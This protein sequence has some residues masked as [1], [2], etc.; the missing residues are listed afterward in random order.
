MSD[1]GYYRYKTTADVQKDIVLYIN[2]A[3]ASTKTIIPIEECGDFRLLKY[4]D[5]NGHYRFYPFNRYYLTTDRPQQIGTTNKFVTN[6]LDD[7][8]DKQNVGFK[9]ERRI[10]V[11]TDVTT[12]QL[13]K[14]TDLYSSPRVYLYIGSN[15]S[16]T[17]QDW[18]E[19]Q[20]E[21]LDP[22][23]RPRRGNSVRV[24][25]SIILPENYTIKM[26]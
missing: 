16:D 8:S 18:L 21:V 24:D 4:L 11:S 17:P 3:P 9:N 20:I 19:V 22:V 2:S 10:D 23:I 1:I 12:T 13:E 14:L 26:I 25:I 7:Q 5:K 6:I 15:N